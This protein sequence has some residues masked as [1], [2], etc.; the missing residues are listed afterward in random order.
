MIQNKKIIKVLVNFL[1]AY[2]FIK[3]IEYSLLILLVFLEKDIQ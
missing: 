2:I 3:I 1:S